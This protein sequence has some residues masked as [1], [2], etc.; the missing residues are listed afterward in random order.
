MGC[1]PSKT[2]ANV[3][4][5]DKSSQKLSHFVSQG[6]GSPLT[7]AS[8]ARNEANMIKVTVPAGVSPGQTIRV[9]TPNGQTHDIAVPS[10]QYSGSSFT[11]EFSAGNYDN[12]MTTTP[13]TVLPPSNNP[14]Y[15]STATSTYSNYNTTS[16]YNT[17][18]ATNNRADDG[19]ASGNN[20]PNYTPPPQATAAVLPDIPDEPDIRL[21]SFPTAQ[22]VPVS[23]TNTAHSQSS[24]NAYPQS[25]NG[26]SSY[27][28]AS[29]NA[30]PTNNNNVYQ[31][32]SNTNND[33]DRYAGVPSIFRPP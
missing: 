29:Y 18:Y 8:S 13:T 31:M 3:Y 26:T 23:H 4:P 6:N 25:P 12:N 1:T 32:N 24:S 28:P 33:N 17:N 2:G 5:G 15:T 19:F 16:N 9:Q 14:A 20:N 7:P 21:Q 10:Q 27:Q 22:A 30:T 11:V